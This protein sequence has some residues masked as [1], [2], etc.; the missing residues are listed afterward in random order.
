MVIA[1]QKLPDGLQ[2]IVLT[3]APDA[4]T[5]FLGDILLLVGVLEIPHP[6]NTL[7]ASTEHMGGA[8]GEG[9]NGAR[10]LPDCAD[11]VVLGVFLYVPEFHSTVLGC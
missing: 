4:D 1:V 8:L 3:I 5:A 6:D 2:L 9:E 11:A 10:M 7:H